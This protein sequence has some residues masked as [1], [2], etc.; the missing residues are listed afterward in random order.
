MINLGL[1][2]ELCA[3]KGVSVRKM[4]M[5]SGL[6]Q[7]TVASMIKNNN[8]TVENLE[9]ISKYFGVSPSLFFGEMDITPAANSIFNAFERDLKD[10]KEFWKY[11]EQSMKMLA[12]VTDMDYSELINFSFEEIH[13][14]LSNAKQKEFDKL[15]QNIVKQ[16]FKFV[17][18]ILTDID[19]TPSMIFLK[20]LSADDIANLRE[21]EFISSETAAFILSF[22]FRVR[23]ESPFNNS[24]RNYLIEC[25]NTVGTKK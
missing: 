1:I 10:I 4:A 16:S 21:A 23:Y 11:D 12:V 13:A 24:L 22:Y 2:K 9:K 7:S 17:K 15:I 19:K 14:K 8:T 20:S 25:V 18:K 6:T 5:D 3:A